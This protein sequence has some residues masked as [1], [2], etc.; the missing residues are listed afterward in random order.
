M[1]EGRHQDQHVHHHVMVDIS[2]KLTAFLENLCQPSGNTDQILSELQQIKE[3][4]N[5]MPTQAEFDA[6]V[7]SINESIT[8]LTNAVAAEAAQVQA[9]IDAHPDLDT[10]KLDTVKANL[11]ALSTSVAQ[12]D[13]QDV[14]PTA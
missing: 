6:Q 9:F 5:T 10:S 2:E 13:P 4:L 11:D 7:A 12:I 1:A 8:A 14:P 3:I